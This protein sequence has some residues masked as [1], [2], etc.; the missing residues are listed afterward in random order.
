MNRSEGL[1]LWKRGAGIFYQAE[2]AL[3]PVSLHVLGRGHRAMLLGC[4]SVDC[5]LS[6]RGKELGVP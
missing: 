2:E 4:V 3:R 1:V 5:L 6:S